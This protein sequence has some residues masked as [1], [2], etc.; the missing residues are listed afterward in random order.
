MDA[1]NRKLIGIRDVIFNS[2]FMVRQY[3]YE[4][5]YGGHE[6]VTEVPTIDADDLDY[7]ERQKLLDHLAI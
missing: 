2:G 5:H 4:D 6:W 1:N 7:S 3:C